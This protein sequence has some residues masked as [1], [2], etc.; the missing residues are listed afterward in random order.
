MGSGLG[1]GC[2]RK[3]LGGEGVLADHDE[4]LTWQW[5]GLGLG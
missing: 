5:L 3:Q 1:L 4:P 2:L